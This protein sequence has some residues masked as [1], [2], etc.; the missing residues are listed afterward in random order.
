L[1]ALAAVVLVPATAQAHPPGGDGRI[2]PPHA[3]FDGVSG[4]EAM[5]QGWF[6]SLASATGPDRC[7]PFGRSGKV[8]LALGEGAPQ[9]CTVEEGT[10]V[11]VIGLTAFCD[12]ASP[13][14]PKT[15]AA[16]IECAWD[17]LEQEVGVESMELTIDGGPVVELLQHKF[18]ACSPQRVVDLPPGN[19]LG[20]PPQRATFTACGWIAWLA[21]LPVGQHTLHSVAIADGEPVHTWSPTIDVQP[22]SY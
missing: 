18:E 8:L 9:T 21:D 6:L 20:A 14:Q 11:F 12:S 5:G 17:F 16:Q 13:P 4:G 1:V 19:F 10:T 7:M 15:R 3:R 2:V 22:R